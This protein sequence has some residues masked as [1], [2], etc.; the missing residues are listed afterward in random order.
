MAKKKRKP[1]SS[2]KLGK[3]SLPALSESQR[4]VMQLIWSQGETTVTDVWN[5]LT[6]KREVARNTVLTVMDRL[7]NRGWLTK[8]RIGN[9][10]LYKA[11]VEQSVSNRQA[12]KRM[13]DSVFS[14]AADQ[15]VAA[16]LSGRGIS[17]EEAARIKKLID[18]KRKEGK[19]RLVYA[20]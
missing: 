11:T 8:R 13:V 7:V 20:F 15:L 17:E 5:E 1:E 9:T 19:K 12:V 14:G 18:A 6:G 2:P 10:Q 16:L 3:K 4:E